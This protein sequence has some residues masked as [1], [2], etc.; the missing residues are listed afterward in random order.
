MQNDVKIKRCAPLICCKSLKKL[1][2][3]GPYILSL[4]VTTFRQLY[5]SIPLHLKSQ[6]SVVVTLLCSV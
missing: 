1:S 3:Y 6:C 5:C 2:P 4:F